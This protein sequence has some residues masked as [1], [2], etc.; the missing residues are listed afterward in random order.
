M[1][2]Q[3]HFFDQSAVEHRLSYGLKRR[4]QEV[5]FLVGAGLSAPTKLGAS[6]V[7][8]ADGLI[9]LIR[10]EFVDDSRQLVEF[11]NATKLGG[12]KKYQAAFLFLQGRL[13]QQTA[14][15]IVR[16][17]VL[18]ARLPQA[19]HLRPSS[20]TRISKDDEL[21]LLEFDGKWSLNPGTAAIGQLITH[22]SEIFGRALLTTNFDP[23]VEI[24]IRY[25]GGQ[26]FKTFLHADGNISQTE[27]PSC[28]VVHLHGYWY[29]SDTLHTN[30]QLQQS[31]PHLKA[32]LAS[33]L[34]NKLVVICGYGGWDDVFTDA[35]MD[36][37]C[38]DSASPEVLG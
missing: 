4:S 15:E 14:N 33:L 26:Y 23:L 17:A 35:L 7:I 10:A 28:H 20:D 1:G 8:G 27:G 30:R 9:E 3:L 19:E 22:Y 5:V 21:R 34:R 2:E 24:A 11:D 37:V 32:S 16:K 6:G 25:A 36:T 29:G 38:D 13:G 31:R 18:A 12:G